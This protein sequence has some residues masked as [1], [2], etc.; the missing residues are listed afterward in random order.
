MNNA[1]VL[2]KYLHVNIAKQKEKTFQPRNGFF[3]FQN[4]KQC[5][6]NLQ[7]LHLHL[8]QIKLSNSEYAYNQNI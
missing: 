5:F 3:R 2:R 4:A 1:F 8:K 7:E 6:D